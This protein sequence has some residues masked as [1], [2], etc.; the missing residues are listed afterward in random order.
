[1]SIA[2][3]KTSPDALGTGIGLSGRLIVSLALLALL[4]ARLAIA[5]SLPIVSDESVYWAW[6]RH[7]AWGYLDHPPMVAWLI[8]VSTQ[9]FGSTP[10][11]VRF[12]AAPL[13]MASVA[14]MVFLAERMA[15][16]SERTRW[17]AVLLLSSPLVAVLSTLMT[18]DT[19]AIFFSACIL[20]CSI[21][22]ME[23]KRSRRSAAGLWALAGLFSGL[24]LVA[25]YTTILTPLAIAG[26]LV[27]SRNGRRQFRTAGP[28]I[29][30]LLA[31]LAFSPV[32]AWNASHQWASF[33]FQLNHGLR[34]GSGADARD[35]NNDV[36]PPA[37]DNQATP[38]LN[39]G[40]FLGGQ[41]LVWNPALAA[42]G[43]IAL[44]ANI[45]R[46][47]TAPVAQHVLIW[48]SII[49]LLFFGLA[50]IRAKG[51][52]N[53][54]AFAYFPLAL[55]TADFTVSSGWHPGWMKWLRGGLIAAALTSIAVSAPLLLMRLGL[56]LPK[57][58]ELLGW[59]EFAAD[60]ESKSAGLPIVC[61]SA[62]DGGEIAFHLNGQPEVPIYAGGAHPSAYD[63][64]EDRPDPRS[65]DRVAYVGDHV[66]VFCRRYGFTVVHKDAVRCRLESGK[67]R[68]LPMAILARDMSPSARPSTAATEGAR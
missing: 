48:C 10:L 49:P 59:R 26:A 66:E 53:W 25:K 1:M 2:A 43:A 44:Y 27:S 3:S 23:E 46:Y 64:M 11:G 57:F 18:P 34:A 68:A 20:T 67:E 36:R 13:A 42:L 51:E 65:M 37:K 47:R 62:R 39:V 12:F 54:P 14:L 55:L 35:G 58:N 40:A 52:M 45:R 29:G 41:A 21:L 56:K 38:L 4:A 61:E 63:Y 7:L 17:V 5:A 8:H 19:P 32:I 15:T 31:L 9:W 30:V 33:R 28:Y 22:A 50:S 24:A 6:S 60:L 16:A